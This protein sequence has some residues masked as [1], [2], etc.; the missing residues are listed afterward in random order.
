MR[1]QPLEL[2]L[3]VGLL[4]KLSGGWLEVHLALRQAELVSVLIW[5]FKNLFLK[6][7]EY[8][9]KKMHEA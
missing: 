1:S 8:K 3:S 4:V 5:I 9:I 6:T 2:R 7:V